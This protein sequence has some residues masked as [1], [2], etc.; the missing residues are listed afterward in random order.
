MSQSAPIVNQVLPIFFLI[1]LGIVTRKTGLLS[2]PAVVAIKTM[3]VRIVLPAVLFMSFL[4]M[5]LKP[6]YFYVFIAV[7][8]I[9]VCSYWA[10]LVSLRLA[11]I[12]RPYAR[13]LMAGYEYGMLGISLFA[14]AYGLEAIGI[15]AVIALGHEI[16]IW[17]VLC[18]LLMIA[19]DGKASAGA[20]V[21]QF[22]KNPVIIAIVCGIGLNMLGVH[23]P[24]LETLPVAGAVVRTMRFLSPMTIPLILICV[25]HGLYIERQGLGEVL[26]LVGI[27]LAFQLPLAAVAAV[28]LLGWV[29]GLDTRFQ[30]ALAT[31]MLLPP[32]FV[33]PLL[34][35]DTGETRFVYK[36]LTVHTLASLALFTLLL[37]GHP[38]L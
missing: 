24:S 9:C 16:F 37:I 2:E 33:V 20:V 28:G 22:S 23:S 3:I 6:D 36:V 25:G 18:T 34:M 29:L 38:V 15:I 4:D 7:F 30:T 11:H 32:P 27:R 17:F 12:A 19:R 5:E 31:L 14:G 8:S 10:G 1:A 13:Y 35:K 21:A 26:K